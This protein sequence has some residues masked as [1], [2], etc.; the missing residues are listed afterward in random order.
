[1]SDQ[2][3][4]IQKNSVS[5]DRM[6]RTIKLFASVINA[7]LG[8]MRTAPTFSL[9]SMSS[10]VQSVQLTYRQPIRAER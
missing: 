5:I 6:L 4:Y 10:R 3:G 2:G 7:N 8:K 9:V 1:M